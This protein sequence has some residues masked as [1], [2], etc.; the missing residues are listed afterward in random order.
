[1]KPLRVG[2]VGAGRM[3]QLH[4]RVYSQLP[5]ISLAG[6]VDIDRSRAEPL[7]QKYQAKAL[8]TPQELAEQVQA[9]SNRML[10]FTIYNNF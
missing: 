10:N 3:G 7:A 4:A 5:D 8:S 1:M 9:V 2:L 6:I